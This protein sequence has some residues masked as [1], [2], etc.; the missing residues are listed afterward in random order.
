[1]TDGP[2][3]VYKIFAQTEYGKNLN[4]AA[5]YNRF[6]PTNY[7]VK[8]WARLLGPD[9]NNL[10]HMRHSISVARWFVKTENRIMINKFSRRDALLLGITAALHDQAEAVTGDIPYGKKS[11]GQ[12]TNEVKVLIA[13]EQVF[14]PK[15]K[16][17][18]LTLYRKGR[19]K[20]AFGNPASDLPGA[21]KVIELI[22]FAEN[23][24]CALRRVE[25]LSN[26]VTPKKA[27]YFGINTSRDNEKVI[28]ALERLYTEV[29]GSGIIGQLINY[30]DRFPSAHT[31]LRRHKKQI[32]Q[33]F[34][35]VRLSTFEWYDVE[36]PCALPGE[37]DRRLKSHYQQKELWE[38]WVE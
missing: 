16:G 24:L 17:L 23:A 1:M 3:S 21:F 29:L 14:E 13:H 32:Q 12:R 9:V 8:N 28:T 5:R 26:G 22:G 33:G 6:R 25:Q 35:N 31:Y 10:H 30:G 36:D 2:N 4:K 34:N 19:D 7:S 38:S 27:E 15:L 37:R 18:S 20:I 11:K